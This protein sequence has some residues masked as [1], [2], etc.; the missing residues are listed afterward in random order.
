MRMQ[1]KICMIGSFAVG[2]TSLVRRF[3]KS[4]FDERYL[5]TLGVKI[6]KKIV[7]LDNLELTLMLWDMEGQ[8]VYNT[9]KT[10][11]LR[12]AGGYLLVADGTRRETLAEAVSLDTQIEQ[13]IGKVPHLVLLNKSDLQDSWEIEDEQLQLLL[14]V[15]MVFGKTSAKNGEGVEW[16]FMTLAKRILEGRSDTIPDRS[17]G[18]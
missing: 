10:S 13:A 14:D 11:Y 18:P 5:T 7:Q 16:A 1:K 3:V 15:G 8:D 6:D 12:G 4:M 2:K 17:G 9:L